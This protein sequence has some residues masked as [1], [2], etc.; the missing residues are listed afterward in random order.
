MK[1]EELFST[2]NNDLRNK[3]W[4]KVWI[5]LEKSVEEADRKLDRQLKM[6]KAGLKSFCQEKRN[7]NELKVSATQADAQNIL[8]GFWVN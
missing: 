8:G 1:I 3:L 5:Q 7:F 6:E 2:K 4:E